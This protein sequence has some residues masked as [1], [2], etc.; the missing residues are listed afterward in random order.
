MPTPTI[1]GL[2]VTFPVNSAFVVKANRNN[3][4]RHTVNAQT[5][6]H[7][8]CTSGSETTRIYWK[9]G[10]ATD[11]FANLPQLAFVGRTAISGATVMKDVQGGGTPTA[12]PAGNVKTHIRGKVFT[13]LVVSNPLQQADVTY[14]YKR[15]R[16][17]LLELDSATGVVTINKGV[18]N[19]FYAPSTRPTPTV[20]K[21]PLFWVYVWNDTLELIPAHTWSGASPVAGSL[22]K[23]L[24]QAHIARN[25][26]I[27]APVK[28]KLTNGQNV[29]VQAYGDSITAQGGGWTDSGT[30]TDTK[31]IATTPGGVIRDSADYFEYKTAQND[32]IWGPYPT[33]WIDAND[34]GTAQHQT[35]GWA[36]NLGKQMDSDYAGTVTLQNWGI[37][38]TN[39]GSGVSG[40]GAPCGNNAARLPYIAAE[41]ADGCGRPVRVANCQD[42]PVPR[43]G[44]LSTDLQPEPAPGATPSKSPFGEAAPV[45][46]MMPAQWVPWPPPMS[47]LCTPSV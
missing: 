22:S 14:S 31:Y 39:S 19:D 23:S 44:Q 35:R 4:V 47:V 25:A 36:Y 6:T 24:L 3:S 38:A 7:D 15:E 2:Q 43:H 32:A 16:Y 1:S 5:V 34:D 8:A 26:V 17:D 11:A 29:I 37:G 27:L 10:I 33:G 12:V 18:E 41:T 42:D 30:S 46:P 21:I 9:Q 28:T 20:G 40:S 45:P 13:D